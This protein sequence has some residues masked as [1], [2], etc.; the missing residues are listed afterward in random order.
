MA[1]RRK[2]S[3]PPCVISFDDGWG[4]NYWNAFPLLK[5]Y[6]LPA[7]VFLATEMIGSPGY[8]NWD[9]VREMERGG[10]IM[11][12]H[13]ATH[14]VL[15]ALD[16]E[17]VR[18][19]LTSSKETIE[20]QLGRSCRWFCY[21][22]GEHNRST[23]KLVREFYSAALTVEHGMVSIGDDPFTIRRIGINNGI[24]RTNSLFACRLATLM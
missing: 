1:G 24:A 15:T 9:Q 19:E 18:R 21:P 5:A 6:K 3:K 4:D 23:Y 16:E 2:F 17:Q 7:H 8:L 14:A 10:I 11:G 20:S 13:T 12:S 22:K